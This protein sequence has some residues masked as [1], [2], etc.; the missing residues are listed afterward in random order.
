MKWQ[1]TV[2][3]WSKFSQSKMMNRMEV[4]DFKRL[5]DVWEY[6]GFKVKKQ[7]NGYSGFNLDETMEYIV[8]KIK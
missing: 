8:T 4:R 7:R 3:D 2:M 1:L 5:K 6:I